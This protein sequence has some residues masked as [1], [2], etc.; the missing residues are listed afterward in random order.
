M[1]I[2][3][4]KFCLFIKICNFEVTKS[5]NYVLDQHISFVLLVAIINKL[6]YEVSL[7]KPIFVLCIDFPIVCHLLLFIDLWRR[8]WDHRAICHLSGYFNP[9][10]MNATTLILVFA[11]LGFS[12]LLNRSFRRRFSQTHLFRVFVS[13]V[14]YVL[15]ALAV[16]IL[17]T[18]NSFY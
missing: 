18:W 11:L 2:A 9:P 1:V 14:S 7:Q 16:M 13:M 4:Q 17:L 3:C 15:I 8:N 6:F 5:S 10:S 12:Y